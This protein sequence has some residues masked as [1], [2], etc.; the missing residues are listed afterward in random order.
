[1]VASSP[2]RASFLDL[3]IPPTSPLLESHSELLAPIFPSTLFP[4]RSRTE[5]PSARST[6]SKRSRKAHSEAFLIPAFQHPNSPYV[7]WTPPVRRRII[8]PDSATSGVSSHYSRPFS[9]SGARAPEPACTP[10]PEVRLAAKKGWGLL[11]QTLSRRVSS[12]VNRIGTFKQP[13]AA[14]KSDVYLPAITPRVNH[15]RS[16]SEED[17]LFAANYSPSPLSPLVVLSARRVLTPSLASLASSDSATLTRWLAARQEDQRDYEPGSMMSME[18]Y[19]TRGSWL[20]LSGDKKRNGE[21]LC[22]VPGCQVHAGHMSM[23][24]GQVTTLDFSPVTENFDVPT[25]PVQ[26]RSSPEIQ[27]LTSRLSSGQK[28]SAPSPL[29]GDSSVAAASPHRRE[30]SMPG[31]WTF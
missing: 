25:T 13:S 6:S 16:V 12:V 31:G 4:P 11:K 5:L 8:R 29:R 19:E 17:N 26:H 21:W 7:P 3:S 20:D 9:R 10:E 27:T 2:L 23:H 18:E 14:Q 1:M 24:A 22:G 28:G 30:M 15:A